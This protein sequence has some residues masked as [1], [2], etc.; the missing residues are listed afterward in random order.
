MKKIFMFVV[1][2]V[3]LVSI[4]TTTASANTITFTGTNTSC[5]PGD[6]VTVSFS[7][8]A[9]SGIAA[10]DSEITYNSKIFTFVDF[11]DGSAFSNGGLGVGNDQNN[12]KFKYSYIN[13]QGVKK[14]GTMLSIRFK[15]ANNAK[16][17][18]KYS[19]VLSISTLI[20]TNYKPLKGNNTIAYVTIGNL[21]SPV[22]ST[23]K[24]S[25]SSSIRP[26]TTS[27][28]STNSATVNNTNSKTNSNS[29]IASN[30]TN[31]ALNSTL[32]E[33]GSSIAQPD[34]DE[35]YRHP[36]AYITNTDVTATDTDINSLSDFNTI[37]YAVIIILSVL[38]V[39][40]VAAMI[41]LII[42]SY[43]INKK[44]I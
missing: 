12:G 17:G 35:S 24:P 13:A 7:V 40:L 25:A 31:S 41:F 5:K 32:T 6:T 36:I 16:L 8:S 44:E 43:F 23:P 29:I 22:S 20:D 4:I 39:L 28:G 27:S 15:V 19:F 34:T 1:S 30:S 9:N 3:L 14:G 33:N 42:K 18:E 26:S 38:A 37:L 21:A 10:I 2:I 11:E